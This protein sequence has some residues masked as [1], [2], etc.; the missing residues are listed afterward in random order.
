LSVSVTLGA[1]NEQVTPAGVCKL[2]P[3]PS[4]KL[5]VLTSVMV[6]LPTDPELTEE[7]ATFP[8]VIVKSPTWMIC[9]LE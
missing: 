4:T 9:A 1:L 5:D 7:G 8:A 6:E 3:T 2:R